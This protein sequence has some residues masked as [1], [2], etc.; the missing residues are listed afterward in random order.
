[1]VLRQ[2]KEFL[3]GRRKM[4][5]GAA[6]DP[7]FCDYTNQNDYPATQK[8]Q[9]LAKLRA[10]QKYSLE[11]DPQAKSNLTLTS[12]GRGL[13]S[14]EFFLGQTVYGYRNNGER[15]RFLNGNGMA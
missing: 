7:N 4:P 10:I 8:R 11:I 14:E 12:R 6:G 3:E 15:Q 9:V 5:I 13:E 1:M 2:D